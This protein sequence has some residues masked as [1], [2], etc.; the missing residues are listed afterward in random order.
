MNK[1]KKGAV[2]F[3]DVLGWKGIW[4]RNPEA[5]DN[6]LSMI[7]ESKRNIK[8]LL[9]QETLGNGDTNYFKDLEIEV[10]SIS[11][12]IVLLTYGEPE[13]AL[14]FHAGVTARIV[15][16]SIKL[17]IPLRGA[18][19]YGEFTERGNVMVGPAIDEVASWY[20]IANWIGVI[21]IPSATFEVEECIIQLIENKEINKNH[22]FIPF[23]VPLKNY[24]NMKLLCCNWP[25]Y[26]NNETGMMELTNY[27][28]LLKPHYPDV[29][30]K[31]L[32][33]L[34]FYTHTKKLK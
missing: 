5:M 13:H 3:L 32:N 29:S 21:Q 1:M 17:G 8:N 22:V 24:P 23:T 34:N 7:K 28:K 15:S 10:K 11:D 12:T 30:L 33:T 9:N 20:E 14:L 27:F 31:L 19:G 6:L 2:T 25:Y 4:Q 16:E 26:F 18:T